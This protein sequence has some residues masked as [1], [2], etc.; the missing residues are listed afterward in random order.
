MYSLTVQKIIEVQIWH[1]LQSVHQEDH[2]MAGLI[3]TPG[4]LENCVNYADNLPNSYERAA[5]NCDTSS[6]LSWK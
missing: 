2:G 6:I 5:W 3:L 1:I 4:T